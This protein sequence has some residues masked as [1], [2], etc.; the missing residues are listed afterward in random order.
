MPAAAWDRGRLLGGAAT[1]GA[2]SGAC[3]IFHG[4]V[5]A[6]WAGAWGN[7]IHSLEKKERKRLRPCV[8]L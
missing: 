2:C 5:S 4:G 8:L 6:A 1:P 7:T 3:L